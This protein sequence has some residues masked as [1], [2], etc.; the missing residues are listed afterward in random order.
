MRACGGSPHPP[1]GVSVCWTTCNVAWADVGTAST[2]D[3][4]HFTWS[5]GSGS[6]PGR[7]SATVNV[8]HNASISKC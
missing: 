5:E 6:D 8:D 7:L 4:E 2:S 1:Q 3:S